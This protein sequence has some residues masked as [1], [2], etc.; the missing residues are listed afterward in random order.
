MIDDFDIEIQADEY[1]DY[2]DQFEE[3]LDYEDW[4]DLR[5]EPRYI[6]KEE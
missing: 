4:Y 6:N 3:V 2:L 1:L 5:E